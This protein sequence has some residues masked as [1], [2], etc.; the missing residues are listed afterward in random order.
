MSNGLIDL[1]LAG[2][3][4]GQV[5]ANGNLVWPDS[6]CIGP[7]FDGLVLFFLLIVVLG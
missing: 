7:V 2:K 6:L 4:D 3:Y 1:T 5:L